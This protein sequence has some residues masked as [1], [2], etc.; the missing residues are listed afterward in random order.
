MNNNIYNNIY[1]PAAVLD[2]VIF[3]YPLDL[4]QD[5]T[6]CKST[7]TTCCVKN[8]STTMNG[9]CYHVHEFMDPSNI[10]V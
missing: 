1:N 2:L 9:P 5:L 6:S 8:L 7:S 4:P 3:E 10:K